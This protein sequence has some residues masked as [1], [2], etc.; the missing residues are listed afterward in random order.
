[1]TKLQWEEAIL[2]WKYDLS[3]VGLGLSCSHDESAE[4]VQP[5]SLETLEPP[6][7]CKKQ[8]GLEIPEN[9]PKFEFGW[10]RICLS[11]INDRSMCDD[12][13]VTL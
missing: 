10:S 11:M 1:M 4:K 13:P 2:H 7:D 5:V 6:Q 12:F 3:F 9:N 8:M